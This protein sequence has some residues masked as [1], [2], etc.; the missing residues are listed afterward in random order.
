LPTDRP[1]AGSA[2]RRS[3]RLDQAQGLV[4]DIAEVRQDY[5]LK[6]KQYQERTGGSI[7]P[8]EDLK[9]H[10]TI[11]RQRERLEPEVNQIVEFHKQAGALS[12]G[13][14]SPFGALVPEVTQLLEDMRDFE[15]RLYEIY[16]QQISSDKDQQTTSQGGT[17]DLSIEQKEAIRQQVDRRIEAYLEEENRKQ[18]LSG[19]DRLTEDD[20]P[21]EKREEFERIAMRLVLDD[22]TS[23][24]E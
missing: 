11:E 18:N 20:V 24:Y 2:A 10:A 22:R 4:A 9:L 19:A 15:K 16:Y 8:D 7:E 3:Q 17:K 14:W 13:S 23:G 6:R 1:E 5:R 21:E 12:G